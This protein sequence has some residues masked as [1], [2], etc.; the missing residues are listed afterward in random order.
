[1]TSVCQ[2]YEKKRPLC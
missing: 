2:S 1:M